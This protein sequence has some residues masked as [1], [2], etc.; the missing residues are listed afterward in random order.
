MFMQAFS[1]APVCAPSRSCLASGREYDR[2]GVA[3]NFCNDYPV[4]QPTFY[5]QL[6]AAGYHTITTGKDDLTKATQPG[7]D[8]TFHQAALGFSDGLRAS[9]KLDVVNKWPTPHEPYGHYLAN[10]SVVYKPGTNISAW[11][12]HGA[13]MNKG[14]H[15]YCDA[16]SFSAEM[17]E[18]NWT[19]ENAL[20]LLK[21]KPA[22][23]PWMMQVNFPG[24]HSP[25]LVTRDMHN[26][27]QGRTYPAPVDSKK[28]KSSCTHSKGPSNGFRCDYAAEIE[29]LDARMAD[30]LAAVEAAG[31][32]DNTLVVFSSDHGEM[33]GDHNDN[34]KTMPW[35]GSASVPLVVYGPAL[36]VPA[37][38][39]ID[40]PVSIMD[41]AGTL[42]DYGGAK[43]ASGMTTQSLR[44]L[45]ETGA[46]NSYREFVNSGLQAH[47]FTE[48]D[49]VQGSGFNWRMVVKA[50]N[51][52]T[53]LKF[54]CC[55]GEC[56]GNPSTAPK[57]KDGWEQAM[58]NTK[59]DP[60]DMH[61]IAPA[62]PEIASELRA[63]LP[64]EFNC[65]GSAASV[66][67]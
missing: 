5:K 38:V 53:T 50:F 62:F 44:P 4:D 1:A 43:P 2:A 59:E 7:D 67:E 28:G 26:A 64:K 10:Q 45:L 48:G 42:M 34:G 23:K 36:N 35:Q 19:T 55:K 9:G 47:N 14:D 58:Y 63:L 66:V 32:M 17:Y 60:F 30:I 57:P 25:F 39:K 16:T 20:T 49:E 22:G 11:K 3:C 41:L 40:T 61:N 27:M 24:P 56:N 31:E 54:I 33:L 12:A 37:N 29:N 15:K 6:Q 13:C 46:A 18:D 65:G 51:A 8:G 21:R 52:S